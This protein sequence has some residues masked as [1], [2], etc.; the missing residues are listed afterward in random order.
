MLTTCY[1][2]PAHGSPVVFCVG[3]DGILCFLRSPLL[4]RGA[5]KLYCGGGCLA[6]LDFRLKLWYTALVLFTIRCSG[7]CLVALAVCLM[8]C[9]H[10]PV[11]DRFGV[12]HR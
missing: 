3:G 5:G 12:R 8:V 6:E 7:G 2:T 1:L 11:Y 9:D 4:T 10:V